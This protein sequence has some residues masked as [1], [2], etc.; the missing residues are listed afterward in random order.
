MADKPLSQA[1][2]QALH[3]MNREVALSGVDYESIF[4]ED[5]TSTPLGEE[6]L[7]ISQADVAPAG[8]HAGADLVLKLATRQGKGFE[9]S[10]AEQL[11]HGFADL[12]IKTCQ[13][14]EWGLQ[15]A[16]SAEVA[17]PTPTHLGCLSLPVF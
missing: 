16:P 14:A 10:M 1:G 4:R 15:G 17:R 9:V 2:K 7:L 6:P 5:S 11:Q 13:Q 8:E 3:A 12:L